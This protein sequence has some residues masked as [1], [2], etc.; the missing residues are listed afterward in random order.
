MPTSYTETFVRQDAPGFGGFLVP[1]GQ[2][3]IVRYIVVAGA[4]AEIATIQ[5]TIAGVIIAQ[6]SIPVGPGTLV[7]E[8]Q[9]VAYAGEQISTYMAGG[10]FLT[11]SGYLFADASGRSSPLE[12][13]PVL[14]GT[15][16]AAR[17]MIAP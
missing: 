7:R 2:R 15:L 9:A 8:L 5:V 13:A 10:V 4:A 16:P 1:Q 6:L 12:T 17:G 3:A 14:P 11:V